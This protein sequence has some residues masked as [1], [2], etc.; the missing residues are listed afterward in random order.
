MVGRRTQRRPG[1]VFVWGESSNSTNKIDL[2]KKIM[3]L[4]KQMTL[5]ETSG[6]TIT[7]LLF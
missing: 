3:G 4:M 7:G 2:R 5:V 1:F 6:N